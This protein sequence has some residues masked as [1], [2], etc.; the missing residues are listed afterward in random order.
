MVLLFCVT[1]FLIVYQISFERF[2]VHH[3]IDSPVTSHLEMT[4]LNVI[5]TVMIFYTTE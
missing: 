1:F 2:T 5:I 3:T 4:K